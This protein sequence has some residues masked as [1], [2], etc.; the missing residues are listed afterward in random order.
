MQPAPESSLRAQE[1]ANQRLLAGVEPG[2][3]L[4]LF[5]KCPARILGTGEV[6]IDPNSSEPVAYLILDGALD[7]LLDPN[8]ASA[9]A[10]L[11]AG[12]GVGELSLIDGR[13]RSATVVAKEPSRVLEV[14]A[15]TFWAL[16]RSSHQAALNLIGVLTERL[17]GNNGTLSESLRLQREFQRHATLDALTGLN[18]RRWLDE[19]V[20]RQLKRS[21]FQGQPL[22][23][24]M[25]DVDRFKSF[26]DDHG[27]LAGDFVL[28]AVAQVLRSR[29]RPTDLVG[30]YGGE[31]FTIVLPGTDR[32]GAVIAAER[33]RRA[34][35]ETDLVLPNGRALPRVTVSLGIAEAHAEATVAELYENADRALYRAK[36]NGRNRIEVHEA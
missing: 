8:D 9:V 20:P 27:H 18:N 3:V 12:D 25:L 36:A 1:L 13:P 5:R 24:V 26:N 33:V 29:L 15:E 17:R 6:L 34:I 23:L 28:F 14:N 30:R 31:E 4:H 19:M 22:T 21:R 11:H 16:I 32:P 2:A 10:T 35:E 7:V